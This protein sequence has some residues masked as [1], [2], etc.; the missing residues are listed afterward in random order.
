[1]A[2]SDADMAMYSKR[3]M[4]NEIKTTAFFN[5]ATLLYLTSD[6]AS[7]ASVDIT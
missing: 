7:F 3:S 2:L 6:W 1:M 4:S 5:S